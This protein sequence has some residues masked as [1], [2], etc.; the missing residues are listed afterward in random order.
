MWTGAD[1]VAFGAG[2]PAGSADP[3]R[4]TATATPIAGTRETLGLREGLSSESAS[5]ATAIRRSLAARA[6]GKKTGTTAFGRRAAS[7]HRLSIACAAW[8]PAREKI[9]FPSTGLSGSGSPARGAM[10]DTTHRESEMEP[11]YSKDR[12]CGLRPK[13]GA[14][15]RKVVLLYR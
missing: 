4:A 1:G 8:V 6:Q 2:F 9:G 15:H 10:E 14:A 5:N 13:F 11:L 3:A 12:D 7:E